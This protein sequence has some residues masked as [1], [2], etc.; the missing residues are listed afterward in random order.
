VTVDVQKRNDERRGE[1]RRK[2]LRRRERRGEGRKRGEDGELF[3]TLFFS[4]EV[5]YFVSGG[6]VRW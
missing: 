2:R 1:G 4:E 5:R 6:V 3:F